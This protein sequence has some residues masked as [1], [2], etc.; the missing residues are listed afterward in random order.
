[1][2]RYEK[3][4]IK[5]KYCIGCIFLHIGIDVDHNHCN[6]SGSN[7]FDARTNGLCRNKCYKKK[8]DKKTNV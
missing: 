7:W 3:N 2:S 5:A 1:M 6:S 4:K 8:I